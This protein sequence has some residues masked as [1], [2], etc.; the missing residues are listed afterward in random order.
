MLK[1][2]LTGVVLLMLGS[3]LA[4][5]GTGTVLVFP[6]DNEANDRNLDWIGEGISEL[7]IERLQSEPDLYVFQRDERTAAF[8]RIGIPEVASVS[9]ATAMNLGWNSGA[10]W[11][12]TGRFTGTADHFDIYARITVLTA[13][14]SSQEIKVS[15]KLDDVIPLTNVLSWQ[16]LKMIAPGTR[17]PESDY[18]SRPPIP[19]SAFENYVRGILINDPQRRA[20]YLENAI[21]LLPSYPAAIF[22]LGRLKYLQGDFKTSNQRLEK[23]APSDPYYPYAQFLVG[24]NSYRLGDFARAVTVFSALPQ[25]YDVS[26][27]LGAAQSAKGESY[28][29]VL[30]WRRAATLEPL[31]SEAPFNIGYTLFGRNDFDG[32]AKSLE[33]ALK[34]QGRDGEAMFLLARSYDKQG[35]NEESQRLMSQAVRRSPRVER[36]LNQPLPKLERLRSNPNILALR[37]GGTLNLWTTDRLTRRARS[38]G[39]TPW[40]EYVQTE[41][42]G[43]SFG[44]AIRELK[45]AMM[46]YPSAPD[47]HILLAQVYERQKNYDQAIQ[48]FQ[49]SI[50]LHPAAEPYVGLARVHRLLNQNALALRA[51]GEALRL[52]PEHPAALAMRSELQ[53]LLPKRED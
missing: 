34:L 24:L 8:D 19:R 40:L 9:R 22:Q 42:D 37:T 30:T 20:E 38:Q 12:I 49:A 51:V 5:A 48:E 35:R 2:I 31:G 21:R 29:A 4:F 33:Q 43:Q 1:R 6:F 47:T 50:A 17:T 18:T 3:A 32:A 27:D 41:I 13:S 46:V 14:G 7:M 39:I 44:D 16:L 53:K 45:M 52:E 15:G 36:W 11:V 25:T 28:G 26:V 23:V 10:D